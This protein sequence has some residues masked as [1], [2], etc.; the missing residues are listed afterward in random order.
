LRETLLIAE[1][2]D[3]HDDISFD[4]TVFGTTGQTITI[5]D[6]NDDGTINY[7]DRFNVNSDVSIVGPGREFLTVSAGDS[8]TNVFYVSGPDTL[9]VSISG[10]TVT[11]VSGTYT[12]AI[13]NREALTL[14]QVA[15]VDNDGRGIRNSSGTLTLKQSQVS[16]NQGGGVMSGYGTL[17]IEDS[18]VSANN[19]SWYGGVGSYGG[20]LTITNSTISGNTS[21][22]YGGGVGFYAGWSGDADL[23]ITNTTITDNTAPNGSGLYIYGYSSYLGTLQISNTIIAGNISTSGSDDV[24]SNSSYTSTNSLIGGDALL[25]PLTDNGGLTRTHALLPGSPAI[26]SGSLAAASSSGSDQRGLSRVVGSIDIG[27]FESGLLVSTDSDVAD[28]DYSH[29]NLSLREALLLAEQIDGHDEITFDPA[30]FGT[31]DQTI[32][33]ADQ[34]DDGTINYQDRF[35]VNSDVSI[36]GP[37]HEFLTVS[38]GDSNTSVFYVDGPDSLEVSISGLT[39]TGV[40]GSSYSA[41]IDNREILTLDQV[42]VSDNSGRGVRNYGELTLKQSQVSGN[43]GGGIYNSQG[44]L[45]IE[46]SEISD[47]SASWYA[48][49]GGYAGN[50]TITNS[51][52][53]G[54][55][56]SWYGGGVGF[57]GGWQN[58]EARLTITNTTIT[59]NEAQSGGGLYVYSNSGTLQITNSIIAG[60]ISTNGSDNI[61]SNSSYTSTNNLIDGGD[62]LLG[63]LA[64][65]GGLTRTHALLPGSPAINSGS[66]AAVSSSDIFSADQRGYSRVVGI[67]DIGAFESGLL[68]STDSDVVDGDYSHGNLSL[69]EALLIAELVDGHDE[70]TFDPA[71]FGTTGQTITIADQNDDGTINYQDRFNVNSDVSIV[72]PG[73]EFLTVSAG[74]SN[75]SVF[76]VDGPD[77][78][79]VSISGLTVTGVSGSSYTAAIYNRENLTLDQVSVS[80]NAGKGI[81]NSNGE[82]TLKQSQVSGNLNTGIYNS[83]GTLVIQDSEISENISSSWYS[84]GIASYGGDLTIANSTISGNTGSYGGGVYFG[85]GWSGDIGLSITDTTITNNSASTGGGLYIYTSSGNSGE[86][87]ISNTIIAGNSSTNGDDNIVSNSFYGTTNTLKHGP[88][89]RSEKLNITHTFNSVTGKLAVNGT[90]ANDTITISVVNNVV[91]VG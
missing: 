16:G 86:L 64:D 49:V 33:I 50:I 54:N 84:G 88:F 81:Q 41:S 17:V 24:V 79:E 61:L 25:G 42:A 56:S 28:G 7:Q 6:Q 43:Q 35:N 34:N 47:N 13:D 40:S 22:W 29:G 69:R 11:G 71:V 76:Y 23:T 63:P 57:Y 80:D 65:N 20:G 30:V 60:N 62:P 52:I 44:T 85:G 83:Q 15:V 67:I 66:L 82:L 45:A 2:V 14:D 10:L 68:V 74:D 89:G 87:L 26:N 31:I 5:A 59:N 70:I 51:T 4:P 9:E 55:T 90:S 78:L 75:T 77:S 12:A 58:T 73:L 18:E 48:G 27:A 32:T 53:S 1:Q 91:A 19:A 3:G 8:N 37:G 38:A 21:S 39:V 36:V 46:A 72:G